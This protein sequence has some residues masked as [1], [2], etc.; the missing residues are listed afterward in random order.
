MADFDIPVLV[1]HVALAIY[2]EG[3]L[4]A[5]W[6]PK[7]RMALD[8][9]RSRLVEYGL[10]MEGSQNGDVENIRLTAKG[11]KRDREHRREND[12]H[13]KSREF[14]RL[15]AHIEIG[16]REATEQTPGKPEKPKDRQE[17][18]EQAEVDRLA[19]KRV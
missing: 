5:A 2:R 8:I 7:L 6:R 11:Q 4:H 15:F 19:K 18:R 10:L 13:R 16:Y 14:D 3:G 1:K 12:A 9:A 17:R